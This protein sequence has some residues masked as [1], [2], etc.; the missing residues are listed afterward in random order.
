[1]VV[2]KT[3]KGRNEREK[4]ENGKRKK[5]DGERETETEREREMRGRWCWDGKESGGMR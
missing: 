1:M 5:L 2:R 4:I 3:R